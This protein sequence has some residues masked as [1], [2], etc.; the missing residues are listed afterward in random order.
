M[1]IIYKYVCLFC[2][3]ELLRLH[4]LYCERA[5]NIYI[6]IYIY[7]HVCIYVY[8]YICIYMYICIFRSFLQK[9][10][11]SITR[12]LLRK[13][14]THLYIYIYIYI[15]MALLQKRSASITRSLSWKIHRC[16]CIYRYTYLGLYCKRELPQLQGLYCER[17]ICMYLYIYT[18]I[19]MALLQKRSASITRSLLRKI[20]RNIH[21]YTYVYLGLFCKR[22]QSWLQG[23][24][25]ERALQQ[26]VS[27]AGETYS[28]MIGIFYNRA[29]R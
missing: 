9:R 1:Y 18:H 24:F 25:C 14:Q 6:Y 10:R 12:S 17:A 2:N 23:L 13:S 29:L 5:I 19:C 7:I 20:H 16:V 3:W 8:L 28:N 21:I 15:C 11:A 27:F 26:Q 4:G 22:D